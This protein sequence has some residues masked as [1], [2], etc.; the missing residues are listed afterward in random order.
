MHL[1]NLLFKKALQRTHKNT[2][3]LYIYHIT[4]FTFIF[5]L[6]LI[7]ALFHCIIFPSFLVTTAV[8]LLL[9]GVHTS[10]FNLCLSNFPSVY[11]FR[12]MCILEKYMV[13]TCVFNLH[14][15]C[16]KS[17]SC[18]LFLLTCFQDVA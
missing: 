13:L 3:T 5:Y 14:K 11:L 16:Y 9:K 6:Y 8:A 17:Y 10:V 18:S 4:D 2:R 7:Y 15:W 12:Y 1:E